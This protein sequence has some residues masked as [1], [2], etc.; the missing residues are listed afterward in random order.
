M[1]FFVC[2]FSLF[3]L[4]CVVVVARMIDHFSEGCFLHEDTSSLLAVVYDKNGCPS[5]GMLFMGLG[6]SDEMGGSM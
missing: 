5:P 2:L 4:F 3:L 1:M 6:R